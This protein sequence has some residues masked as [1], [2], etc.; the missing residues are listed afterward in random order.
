[1]PYREDKPLAEII[2]PDRRRQK[3]IALVVAS[4]VVGACAL[5]AVQEL[6][7]PKPPMNTPEPVD[8][9]T[10]SIV[11]DGPDGRI[12][13]PTPHEKTV[14]HVWLQGCA[15]CMPAFEAMKKIESEGGLGV[16]SR[17]L[18]VAYGTAEPEWASKYGV[19]KNLVFDRGG[20]NIVR[21]LGISSF[22]TL[23][24]D[25]QG[26][27]VARDR[28]D[29]PGYVDRIRR[30]L[31]EGPPLDVKDIETVIA[32]KRRDIVQECWRGRKVDEAYVLVSAV[33]GGDGTV[34]STSSKG[35]DPAIATCIENQVKTWR[36]R[37]SG[38]PSRAV[39]IPFKLQRG[40]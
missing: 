3:S 29:R 33:V 18:N 21:P 36:F 17:E 11:L 24:Y 39:D 28:P 40:D 34:V 32:S 5:Y 35:S 27:I 16:Q 7:K 37:A 23:V 20:V 2:P 19:R 10:G 25:E 9:P 30:A 1:M 31:G 6:T 13:V 12:A 14:V 26:R 22:T 8:V 15:D 4:M 38:G